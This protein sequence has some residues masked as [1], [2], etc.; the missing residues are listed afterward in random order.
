VRTAVGRY[1][2]LSL[3]EVEPQ[4]WVVVAPPRL[5]KQNWVMW[6]SFAGDC[7]RRVEIRIGDNEA[8]RPRN[9]PPDRE[10]DIDDSCKG[11]GSS[12]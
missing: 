11:K 5:F 12:G 1:R 6:L 2:R 3:Q 10:Y 9:G 8:W 7:L 4:R